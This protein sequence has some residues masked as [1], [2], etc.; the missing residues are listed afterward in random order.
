[1]LAAAIL[2]STTFFMDTVVSMTDSTVQARI[3][4]PEV[5]PDRTVTIRYRAPGATK[6]EVGIEGTDNVPMVKDSDGV[7]SY[8]TKP[9]V[10]DIYGYTIVV[11]GNSQLD[12]QNPL[13]KP[14][15]IWV[16][17]MVKVPGNPPDAWEVQD[18]PHGELHRHFY[19]SHIIGDQRDYFVYTPPGYRPTAG[20]KYP[21]L[22]LLHGFSDTA[23]GWTSVGM[24]HVIMDNLIAQGKAKPMLIVMTL[25]YGVPDFA[26]PGG[27][28]FGD[29]RLT[30]ESFTK[31]RDA[32]LTEVVPMIEREYRT[33]TKREDRAIAGLSMGGAESLFVGLNNL[34][35]FAYIGAFSSGG[36]PA[37]KPEDALLNLSA[38]EAH[39]LKAFYISCGKEDGLIGF[40]RG[41]TSW[42]KGKGIDFDAVE[43]PGRHVW[44]LW[45]RNLIAFSGMLFK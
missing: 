41:F 26:S 43:T 24:A 3:I 7:W 1:M 2:F 5:H 35:K 42:L 6:V 44:M 18:V 23:N 4:S 37:D 31:F 27:R 20:K 25:G 10:P 17:N 16:G 12:P 39:K 38:T 22:Y 11:D 32:L 36:L 13:I 21:V 40:H 8:T 33:L 28:A 29:R 15:L 34:D 19:K 14:N 30:L 45:R 9:L